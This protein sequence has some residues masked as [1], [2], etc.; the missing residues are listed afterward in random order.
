MTFTPDTVGLYSAFI[1]LEHNASTS[2][3]SVRVRADVITSY[4]SADDKFPQQNYPNPFNS[5]TVISY[6]LIKAA[7]ATLRVYNVLGQVVS[8][9]LNEVQQPGYYKIHFDGKGL[10]TGIY[11]YRLQA[12]EYGKTRTF[13]LLQ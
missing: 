8:T 1:I 4:I 5:S 2:P 6:R 11:Y 13:I 7:H 10:S 3:D 9:L 12:G